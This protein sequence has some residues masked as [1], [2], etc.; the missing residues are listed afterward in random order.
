LRKIN[1][2]D[3]EPL[4]PYVPGIGARFPSKGPQGKGGRE[5]VQRDSHSSAASSSSGE[6]AARAVTVEELFSGAGKRKSLFQHNGMDEERLMGMVTRL[7]ESGGEVGGA[8]YWT[9]RGVI[10]A[11]R[12]HAAVWSFRISAFCVLLMVVENEASYFFDARGVVTI[13]KLLMVALSLLVVI[14]LH[15]FHRRQWMLE[16]LSRLSNE[17][18][19]TFFRSRRGVAFLAESALVL[20]QVPPFVFFTIRYYA[21]G[22]LHLSAVTDTEPHRAVPVDGLSLDW[23]IILRLLFVIRYAT[24]T[25]AFQKPGA[26]LIAAFSKIQVSHS[27]TIRS[28]AELKP[29]RF[30]L[31]FMIPTFFLLAYGW[32]IVERE[33][34]LTGVS[35]LDGMWV[36][37]QTI[38]AVGFG[39]LVP[40]APFGR[41]FSLLI[42]FVGVLWLAILVTF[43]SDWLELGPTEARIVAMLVRSRLKKDLSNGSATVIQRAVALHHARRT[44][45][46]AAAETRRAVSLLYRAIGSFREIKLRNHSSDAEHNKFVVSEEI[47]AGVAKL[48]LKVAEARKLMG[49]LAD[50]ERAYAALVPDLERHQAVIDL[51][52]KRAAE[53]AMGKAR[54]NAAI[55]EK[56]DR[57]E[58]AIGNIFDRAARRAATIIKV[59]TL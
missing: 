13:T 52:R 15:K 18:E 59:E 21:T 51:E 10:E 45:G 20:L 42:A 2:N 27:F 50:H 1:F 55:A 19:N 37:G 23:F 7:Q 17:T 6:D 58:A 32:Y 9:V 25:S 12:R 26:R 49:I 28:A 8:M 30:L 11:D 24:F 3:N 34:N 47:T 36:V 43:I 39:D 4:S 46:E 29:F 56:I 40:S 31:S 41:F 38:I 44:Y 14:L 16:Q 57:T 53:E 22:A 35:Y 5:S 48:K 54:L 33:A